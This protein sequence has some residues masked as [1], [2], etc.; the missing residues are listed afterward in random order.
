MGEQAAGAI[1]ACPVGD[2]GGQAGAVAGG[3]V[4]SFVRASPHPVGIWGSGSDLGVGPAGGQGAAGVQLP[5]ALALLQGLRLRP[6]L[7]G[8]L[9][10]KH[11]ME[12][13]KNKPLPSLPEPPRA[14]PW[15]YLTKGTWRT[16]FWIF[17]GD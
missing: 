5:G 14:R 2:W 4:G 16:R 8:V 17:S 1:W 9:R 7:A 3:G 13:K 10:E 11:Q 15:K 12:R 6:L